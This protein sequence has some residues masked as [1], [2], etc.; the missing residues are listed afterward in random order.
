VV[1]Q[2]VRGRAAAD[3]GVSVSDVEIPFLGMGRPLACPDSARIEVVP[4]PGEAWRGV[5]DVTVVG[6]SD[7]G[8]TCDRL[9]M[10]PR[11]EVWTRVPVAAAAVA[12]GDS[13]ILREGRVLRSSLGAAVVSFGSE[14]LEARV[15]LAE[16]EPVTVLAVRPAPDARSGD[17]VT[18]LVESG[19]LRIRA[20][21]RLMEDATVGDP[22]RVSNLATGAV[23]TGALVS[24]GLVRAGGSR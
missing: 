10:R 11:V 4:A 1:E 20:P 8:V 19:A 15:P 7:R 3:L 14:G 13:V 23:M 2:A 6:V 24:P 16:G 17:D 5:S 9:R 18:L 21:G 12:A 22:V